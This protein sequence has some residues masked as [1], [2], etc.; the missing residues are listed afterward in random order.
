MLHFS[1]VEN[2]LALDASLEVVDMD[3]A[4]PDAKVWIHDNRTKT[5]RK[6]TLQEA[7]V[8]GDCKVMD[9]DKKSGWKTP[10]EFAAALDAAAVVA[11]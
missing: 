6:G 8:S 2:P 11:Q 9:K 4:A 10:A 5:I 3:A 7:L 1:Y